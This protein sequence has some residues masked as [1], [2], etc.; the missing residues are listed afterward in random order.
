VKKD[1][2]GTEP[3]PV[4]LLPCKLASHA[5]NKIDIALVHPHKSFANPSQAVHSG[6]VK[7][8]GA[9]RFERYQGLRVFAIVREQLTQGDVE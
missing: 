4:L 2:A 1:Q 8:W 9:V 5:G 6:S 3:G 7:L